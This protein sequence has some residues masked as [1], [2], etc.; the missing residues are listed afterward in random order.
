M[1]RE[2]QA[3]FCERLG[4]KLPG[5]TRQAYKAV[6]SYNGAAGVDGQTFEQFVADLKRNL[7]KI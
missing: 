7:Y 2:S 3:R 1:R 6:K 5:P 4:V